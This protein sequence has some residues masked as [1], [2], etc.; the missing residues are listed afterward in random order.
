M[1]KNILRQKYSKRNQSVSLCNDSVIVITIWETYNDLINRYN[2]SV[3]L[4]QR[5]FFPNRYNDS[6]NVIT[7]QAEK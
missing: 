4:I 3:Q 1:L 6:Q 7:F 5:L 2:V